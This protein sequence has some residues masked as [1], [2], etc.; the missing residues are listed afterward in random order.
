MLL[1]SILFA[2]RPRSAAQ[3]P[4]RRDRNNGRPAS[5]LPPITLPGRFRSKYPRSPQ[6]LSRRKPRAFT[7]RSWYDCRKARPVPLGL[8]AR[9]WETR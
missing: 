4:P 7:L 5:V 9:A 1:R 3:V 6:P 8:S 2:F